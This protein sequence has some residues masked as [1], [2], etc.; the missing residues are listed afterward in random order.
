MVVT[1]SAHILKNSRKMIHTKYFPYVCGS[2]FKLVSCKSVL[3]VQGNSHADR[4]GKGEVRGRFNQGGI[5]E[6]KL[7]TEFKTSDVG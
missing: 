2:C 4:S 5:R 1:L 6:L 3:F 7:S